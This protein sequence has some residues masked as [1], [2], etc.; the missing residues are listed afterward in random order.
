MSGRSPSRDK[1][2]IKT[3]ISAAL[4]NSLHVPT[5]ALRMRVVAACRL[6]TYLN[7]LVIV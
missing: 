5:H 3:E 2:I 4:K 6:I 1:V 7:Y